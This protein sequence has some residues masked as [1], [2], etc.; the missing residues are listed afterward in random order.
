MKLRLGVLGSTRGTHLEP[1]ISAIRQQTIPA[2]IE[3]V[4]SNKFEAGILER[5]KHYRIPSYFINPNGSTRE[6]FDRQVSELLI[7]HR[8]DLIVLIGY[9]RIL[10]AEFIQAWRNKVINVHPSLLPAYAG[11]MDMAVHNA[12]IAADDS[13]SGC[14]VHYVTEEVDAGPILLQKQ[15]KINPGETPEQLK[16]KV[17]QLEAQALVQAIQNISSLHHTTK[18]TAL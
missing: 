7:H 12:V 11:M 10:S 16:A 5:A 13:F 8:V 14:T 4:I 9:M 18:V 2:S 17:Q 6:A 3:V 1:I 15:C